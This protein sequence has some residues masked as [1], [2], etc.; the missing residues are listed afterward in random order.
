MTTNAQELDRSTEAEEWSGVAL[1]VALLMVFG[2]LVL[3]FA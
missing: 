1:V 2:A 3:L